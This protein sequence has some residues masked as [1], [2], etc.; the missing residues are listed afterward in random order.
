MKL[1]GRINQY[2]FEDKETKID[3]AKLD[4]KSLRSLKFFFGGFG[5]ARHLFASMIDLSNQSSILNKKKKEL[6]N[7]S[8]V[9]NDIKP[10]AVA[11]MLIM[12]SALRNLNNYSQKQIE[13][14]VKAAR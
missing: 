13:T 8:F 10:H 3:L 9:V 1:K 7:V 2:S 6:L 12:F 11:K 5:D 4:D 14:D